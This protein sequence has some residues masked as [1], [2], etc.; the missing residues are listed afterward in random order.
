MHE[1]E[2][3]G[4]QGPVHVPDDDLGS[5]VHVSEVSGELEAHGIQDGDHIE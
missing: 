5:I 3:V 1:R 2:H 4:V